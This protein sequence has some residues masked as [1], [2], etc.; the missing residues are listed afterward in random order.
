MRGPGSAYL[1]NTAAY[2][3][4]HQRNPSMP[5][6]VTAQYG[7]LHIPDGYIPPAV[8]PP[9]V[10]QDVISPRTDPDYW[11]RAG[12]SPQYRRPP[13][14]NHH[15]R[16]SQSHP[17]VQPVNPPVM[18]SLH[19]SDPTS[20]T[21][22]SSFSSPPFKPFQ[23]LP[24]IRRTKPPTPPPK[25]L[26]L[27]PYRD[28]FPDLSRPTPTSRARALEI[29]Q[30]TERTD[31][32]LA[33]EEWRR[34]DEEREKIIQ[35]KREERER[36][37]SGASTIRAPT[38]QTVTALVVDPTNVQPPPP[39]PK[40]KRSLWKRLFRPGRSS[41][42]D[43]QSTARQPTQANGANIIPIDA[44]FV[45]PSIPGLV[46]PM[47]VP[48]DPQP[49]SSQTQSSPR[50]V[51]QPTPTP[52]IPGRSGTIRSGA[53]PNSVGP[54]VVMPSPF[55]QHV[56]RSTTPDHSPPNAAFNSM[57]TPGYV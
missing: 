20:G 41:H 16:P 27:A 35:E 15:R 2:T 6:P 28:A 45:L 34:Q 1:S 31:I 51:A 12:H 40:E 5:V 3:P 8:N 10:P 42:S 46:V 4:S 23:P 39:P 25:L 52:V 17:P 44:Q 57:P 21:L 19:Y 22:T 9:V 48:N 7:N 55:L 43:Q 32:Q 50:H 18:P 47:P 53:L 38:M 33:Q 29:I 49:S 54:Q 14:Q 37:I 11:R 30:N 26:E 13:S 56:H 36:L 24:E